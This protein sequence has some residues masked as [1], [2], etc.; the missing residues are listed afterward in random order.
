MT[1]SA[2]PDLEWRDF[3]EFS[4]A[5]L[6][7]ILRFRQ[8]IF[9]VEQGSPYADLDGRDEHAHHLL[10]RNDRALAGYLRLIPHQAERRVTIG[11]VAVGAAWRGRGLARALMDAALSRCQREYP[12]YAVTLSAQEYLVPF[13]RR[14]GFVPTSAPYDDYGVPHVDMRLE[15][16]PT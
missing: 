12:D 8:A 15:C 13:Y 5:Q 3:D 16:G 9:V 11:R 1:I 2:P 6:Y 14:L 10:L 4:G 7:D